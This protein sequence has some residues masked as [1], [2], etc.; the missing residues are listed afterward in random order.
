MGKTK[1]ILGGELCVQSMGRMGPM[2]DETS[3]E[4][5]W[6]QSLEKHYSRVGVV[7]S[8]HQVCGCWLGTGED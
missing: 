7:R 2:D 8:K 6:M 5:P 4:F 1:I 3:E